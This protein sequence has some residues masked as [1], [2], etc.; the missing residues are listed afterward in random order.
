M[1]LYLGSLTLENHRSIQFSYFVP[2]ILELPIFQNAQGW[3]SV[4]K[5]FLN[6]CTHGTSNPPKNVCYQA[7]PGS[8]PLRPDY[9][10]QILFFINY[11]VSAQH[12]VSLRAAHPQYPSSTTIVFWW[13]AVS[14]KKTTK[15]AKS[16]TNVTSLILKE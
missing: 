16:F 9:R 14:A 12:N 7:K 13:C 8:T 4:I 6:V 1:Y 11:P 5:R 2:L 15:S 3:Q 10:H